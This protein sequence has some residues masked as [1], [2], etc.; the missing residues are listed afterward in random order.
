[1]KKH[2]KFNGLIAATTM[3]NYSELDNEYIDILQD[4]MQKND[5]LIYD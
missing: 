4:M 1:M 2:K 5:F 3:V